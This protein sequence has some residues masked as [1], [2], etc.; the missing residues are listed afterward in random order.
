MAKSKSLEIW[1]PL[2]SNHECKIAG[3]PEKTEPRANQKGAIAIEGLFERAEVDPSGI[4]TLREDIFREGYF[5]GYFSV[6]DVLVD[7]C[8][9]NN[10][11]IE[12]HFEPELRTHVIDSIVGKKNWWYRAGYNGKVG[13]ISKGA[14]R[15][16][17][18]MDLFPYKD[19]DEY[20]GLSGAR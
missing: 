8:K 7:T 4:E 20:E 2:E 16:L 15:P 14:E 18:R 12:Y 19:W 1:R 5:E 10:I 3:K 6:F 11:D 13:Q 9:K 17:H